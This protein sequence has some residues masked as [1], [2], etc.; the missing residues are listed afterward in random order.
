[1]TI[2]GSQVGWAV[3]FAWL[4]MCVSASLSF[5]SSDQEIVLVVNDVPPHGLVVTTV[6]LPPEV[7]ATPKDFALSARQLTTGE[8]VPLQYVPDAKF[9]TNTKSREGQEL[10]PTAGLQGHVIMRLPDVRAAAV[11]LQIQTANSPA[12]AKQAVCRVQN[13]GTEVVHDQQL[14]GGFPTEICFAD[15]SQRFK[16]FSWNDRIYDPDRGSYYL[17]YD[18]EATLRTVADGPICTVIE[19]QGRYV[20]A[21]GHVPDTNPRSIYRWHYFHDTP[22]V[23]VTAVVEQDRSQDWKELHFL[24]LNFP[25]EDFTRWAGGTPRSAGG[26]TGSEASHRFAN[27]AAVENDR[28]AIGMFGSGRILVYDGRGGYGTYLHAS[29]DL[30][31]QTWPDTRRD[32]SGWLWLGPQEELMESISDWQAFPPDRVPVVVTRRHVREQLEAAREQAEAAGEMDRL[33]YWELTLAE[34]LEGQGRFDE[35]L[36][37]LEGNPP[38]HWKI[39]AAGDLRIVLRQ[40]PHGIELI[41]LYDLRAGHEH[42]SK[43]TGSLFQV[44]LKGTGAD[45]KS[46]E[47]ASDAGWQDVEIRQDGSVV[48]LCWSHPQIESCGGVRVVMQ[49]TADTQASAVSWTCHVDNENDRLSVW[50]VTFP[51][52]RLV[53]PGKQPV[54][55]FPRGPGEVKRDIWRQPFTYQGLYPNGWTT[56]QFLA[57][58]DQQQRRGLYVAAHD[59]TGGTKNLR[60]R[61]HPSDGYVDMEVTIPVPNM[62]Q[63]HNSYRQDGEMVWQLFTGDWFDAAQIYREWVRSRARWFPD[64]QA[65]GR[66]D[67]PRWM[68]ELPVW[69]MTGGAPEECVDQVLRFAKDVDVPVGFHWYNWHEIPFDNDYPHYFPTKPGFR[70]GVDR[71]REAGVFVMPYINGRLW[72]TKDRGAEDGEFSARGLS[73]A[74][75]D[76]TGSPYTETYGSKESDGQ[77]VELAAM[78][79]TTDVWQRELRQITGRLFEECGVN[80]IYIDQIAA[81]A[82]KLCF[83]QQHGH[84]LGGGH[85]WTDGYWKLLD[86]IRAD[87]PRDR[88]LT[89]ECNADPYVRW[90]DGYLT[91]HWQYDGQVPAFP[92]VYGGAIQMFGRAYRGGETQDLALRMKAGQQLVFGEQI[93]WFHPNV[94]ER[95]AGR[96]FLH[97]VIGLRWKLRRFFSAGEMARPPALAGRIPTVRA[98]WRW[99]GTWWVTTDAVMT[100]AWRLPT[101]G[102]LILLFANVS[103]KAV[104]ASY[105]FDPAMYGLGEARYQ[106]IRHT[107]DGRHEELVT[108]GPLARRLNFPPGSA[109]AW[110]VKTLANAP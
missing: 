17:K 38:D 30:A 55:L 107:A 68:R 35:S 13:N 36:A 10:Q 83:D 37:M 90:F 100:G 15:P 54:A 95:P 6:D 81:A 7:L 47:L 58:Y 78:C 86:Q 74:T 53:P 91:W 8:A 64:L 9:V 85:W 32:D 18:R 4:L 56:M 52:L 109:W 41:S 21:Q 67:T 39:I 40:Q 34:Q 42:L 71:L 16:Q 29:G 44:Q 93:G 26:L 76:E 99:S 61:S 105:N 23:W 103:E 75:K 82:P 2:R 70:S 49:A 51:E 79:P 3:P 94:L 65:E 48:T 45:G 104:E 101:E 50:E 89:T 92:A 31:W 11:M 87:M 88:M 72:D 63:S 73:G 20:D 19:S 24:E 66:T 62:G 59:P 84:P 98:D 108:T 12:D 97:Q 25:G 80:G 102:R 27:W 106:L 5:A 46:Y 69:V 22:L 57:V 28:N 43:A 96:D 77:A 60:L 110:E 33:R 1:M 14:A